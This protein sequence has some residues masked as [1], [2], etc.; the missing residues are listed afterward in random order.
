[1]HRVVSR[2]KRPARFG[3]LRM[4]ICEDFDFTILLGKACRSEAWDLPGSEDE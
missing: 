2:S 1:M 4:A 3:V